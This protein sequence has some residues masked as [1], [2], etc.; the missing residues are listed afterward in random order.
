MSRLA[1]CF[2]KLKQQNQSAF[3]TFITAGDPD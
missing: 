1:A 2:A 3:V